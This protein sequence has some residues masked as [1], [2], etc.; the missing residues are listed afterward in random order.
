L[1]ALLTDPERFRDPSTSLRAGR[2]VCCVISGGNVD[3]AVYAKLLS[4]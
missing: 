4:G 1:G 2:H 3:P